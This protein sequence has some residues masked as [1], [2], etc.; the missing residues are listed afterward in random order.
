VSEFAHCSKEW[1]SSCPALG[2]LNRPGI[3]ADGVSVFELPAIMKQSN[4]FPFKVA[5]AG[6]DS[7]SY[8]P[9]IADLD[10]P[11]LA[12]HQCKATYSP[13]FGP[14]DPELAEGHWS[15]NCNPRQQTPEFLSTYAQTNPQDV[16][17]NT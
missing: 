11:Y 3:D 17:P 10:N 2:L 4:I 7:G 9:V 16:T 15:I 13:Q 8:Y 12:E 14:P 6:T 1:L 5:F